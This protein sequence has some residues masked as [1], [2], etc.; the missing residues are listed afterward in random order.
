MNRLPSVSLAPQRTRARRTQLRSWRHLA[1]TLPGDEPGLLSPIRQLIVANLRAWGV[2][3]ERAAD[4]ELC[5]SELLT[6]VLRYTDGS[7]RLHLKIREGAIVLEVSDTSIATPRSLESDEEGQREYGRGLSIVAKLA[8]RVEVRIR[9]SYGKTVAA[10][11][12]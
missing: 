9:P 12:G 8:S 2:D 1:L 4:V 5:A 10:F 6:N 7:A 11:F 3:P